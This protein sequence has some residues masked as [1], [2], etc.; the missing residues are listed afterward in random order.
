MVLNK[1]TLVIKDGFLCIKVVGA[2]SSEP[3]FT[4]HYYPCFRCSE[5]E[6]KM[7]SYP[8]GE[9]MTPVGTGTYCC[10]SFDYRSR[11]ELADGGQTKPIAFERIPAQS[12]KSGGKPVRWYYGQWQKLLKTGWVHLPFVAIP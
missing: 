12:P 2:C 10:R 1:H 11:F 5:S 8:I 9:E 3:E 7:C 6:A 4:I